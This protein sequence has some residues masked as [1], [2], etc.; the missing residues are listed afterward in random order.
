VYVTKPVV[1]E[2]FVEAIKRLGLLLSILKVPPE[3][4]SDR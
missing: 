1:Y 2:E 4:D 3:A